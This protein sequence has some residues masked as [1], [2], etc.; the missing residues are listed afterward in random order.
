[1]KRRWNNAFHTIAVNP[2]R[3]SLV[4]KYKCKADLSTAATG[5]VAAI[6]N[7]SRFKSPQKLVSYF[8]LNPRVGAAAVVQSTKKTPGVRC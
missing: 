3:P 1:M 7:I 5:D 2:R 6:G 8:G 4:P